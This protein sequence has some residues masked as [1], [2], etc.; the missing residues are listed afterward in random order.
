MKSLIVL[1]LMWPRLWYARISWKLEDQWRRGGEI[2]PQYSDETKKLIKKQNRAWR[3][4]MLFS[5]LPFGPITM[6]VTWL[7]FRGEKNKTIKYYVSQQVP[8]IEEMKELRRQ[9]IKTLTEYIN[10][11]FN[12]ENDI[13]W[14]DVLIPGVETEQAIREYLF[15]ENGVLTRGPE[16]DKYEKK[17]NNEE[18]IEELNI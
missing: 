5:I 13:N 15:G 18:E 14:E 10:E 1:L 3:W 12:A 11:K 17:N 2:P 16:K 8:E 6:F 4:A 7:A 9:R